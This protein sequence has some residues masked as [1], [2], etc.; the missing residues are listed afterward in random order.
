MQ[1]DKTANFIIT[2]KTQAPSGT[3]RK[4]PA[5][6]TI[7]LIITALAL[8]AAPG[9]RAEELCNCM[10]T[11]IG[12]TGDWF[13][14]ANW[15]DNRLPSCGGSVCYPLAGS[16]QAFISNTGMAQITSQTQTA[17][18]CALFLGRYSADSGRLSVDHGTLN[19]C[20]ELDVGTE[21]R[22]RMTIT[23]GGIASTASAGASIAFSTGSHGS[24]TV[25]GANSQLIG[26]GPIYVGGSTNGAG[27]DGLLTVT[28]SATVTA[29]NVHVYSSGT[30]TGNSTVSTTS[31]TTIEGTIAPSGTPPNDR[32]TISSGDL[33]FGTAALMQC[34]VV[35]AGADNVYVSNGTASLSGK[36]SVSM[37]M[38]ATFT[39][40]T[41]YTLL[42]AN[43]GLAGT[44]FSS[45]S[46]TFPTGQNFTPIIQYDYPNKNVNLYL[47][48][49][50]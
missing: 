32:I 45:V 8:C 5:K 13:M 1:K 44:S 15:T 46:I 20:G 23:N 29:T 36:L 42:H 35:P 43:G 40:G 34:N 11:W 37:S 26:T 48:P 6:N 31:G 28:N 12:T 41:T 30:L 7:L 14:P 2:M 21:G 17:Y 38:S 47:E 49:N 39:P 50:T 22:G 10:T 3:A 19:M 18:A 4:T 9:P 16:T 24:V 33:T 25:D 27:G